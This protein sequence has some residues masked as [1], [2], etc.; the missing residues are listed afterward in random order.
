MGL[1]F[2]IAFSAYDSETEDILD[3]SYG[4]LTFTYYRWG[5]DADGK[6]W[7]EFDEIPSHT[8]SQQ[9]LGLLGQEASEFYPTTIDKQKLVSLY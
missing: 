4:N 1:N 5:E 7:L 2:A 9:E 6:P 3:P 8:C